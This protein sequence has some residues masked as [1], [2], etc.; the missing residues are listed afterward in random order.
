M[1]VVNVVTVECFLEN[2][3]RNVRYILHTESAIRL[4][5]LETREIINYCFQDYT[6]HQKEIVKKL[7]EIMEAVLA[8]YLSK[9]CPVG[10]RYGFDTGANTF[11]LLTLYRA[12]SGSLSLPRKCPLT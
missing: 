2:A 5:H 11:N 8:R 1:K 9:V 10:N 6:E 4:L 3:V 7:I 12:S